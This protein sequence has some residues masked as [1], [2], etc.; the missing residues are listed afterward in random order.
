MPSFLGIA[1]SFSFYEATQIIE[2]VE[3]ACPAY[4]AA[5]AEIRIREKLIGENWFKH[6]T[7]LAHAFWEMKRPWWL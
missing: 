3:I 5:M 7:E 2:P 6:N 1:P 4:A